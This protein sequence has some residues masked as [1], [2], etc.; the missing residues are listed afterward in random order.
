M[1][2]SGYTRTD[3]IGMPVWP[4]GNVDALTT[5]AQRIR[6]GTP[7]RVGR[8]RRSDRAGRWFHPTSG[9]SGRVPLIH[10]TTQGL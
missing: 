5:L 4:G 1:P 8:L 9:S 3:P 10:R 2:T 6:G 7:R